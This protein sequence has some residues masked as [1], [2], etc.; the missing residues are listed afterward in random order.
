MKKIFVC[1]FTLVVA[2]TTTLS[3][4]AT[5]WSSKETLNVQL[6]VLGVKERKHLLR[7]TK[8]VTMVIFIY[9]LIIQVGRHMET[10]ISMGN[11]VPIHIIL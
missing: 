3:I 10:F 2:L 6:G 5:Q 11:A 7:K 9:I 4:S 1:F 8:L